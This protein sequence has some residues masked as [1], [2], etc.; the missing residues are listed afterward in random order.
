MSA[1]SAHAARPAPPPQAA[2]VSRRGAPGGPWAAPV[3]A[4]SCCPFQRSRLP[5]PAR[6]CS[7]KRTRDDV[8]F[9]TWKNGLADDAPPPEGTT[10]RAEQ[11]RGA[12]R[13]RPGPGRG[14]SQPRLG[15]QPP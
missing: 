1:R 6:A 5:D 8:A 13:V 7:Q 2:A 14:P 10:P 4:S 3:L 11:A 12:P 9:E 15:E